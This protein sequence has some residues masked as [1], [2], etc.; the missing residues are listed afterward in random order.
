MLGS[1]LF[2]KVVDVVFWGCMLL[3]GLLSVEDLVL[4]AVEVEFGRKR[5]GWKS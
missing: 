5:L 4:V 3:W 1:L 2:M